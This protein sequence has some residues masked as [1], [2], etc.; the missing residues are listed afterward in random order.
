MKKIAVILLIVALLPLSMV[1]AKSAKRN[2]KKFTKTEL[3]T[4]SDSINYAMGYATGVQNRYDELKDDTLNSKKSAS[5]CMGIE[6]AYKE[7]DAVSNARMNGYAIAQSIKSIA[8]GERGQMIPIDGFKLN[9]DTLSK[10]LINAITKN[11]KDFDFKKYSTFVNENVFTPL[12]NGKS[13]NLTQSMTDSISLLFGYLNGTNVLQQ[14]VK[15][16]TNPDLIKTLTDS[17][18]DYIYSKNKINSYNKGEMVGH[19]L[20]E[21]IGD[22]QNFFDSEK[23]A[24]NKSMFLNGLFDGVMQNP[25]SPLDF[26]QSK[27]YLDSVNQKIQQDKIAENEKLATEAAMKNQQEG[28]AFLLNNGMRPE[29]TTTSSGLQYEIVKQGEGPKPT[30][31]STVKVHYEGKFLDGTVFDSSINR[32]EPIEF[33]PTQVI[34]GWTEGLKLMPVGS[35]YIFYIPYDLAYGPNGAGGVI[36]PYATLIFEVELLEIVD[37]E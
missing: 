13:I 31:S 32:G 3:T 35:K 10:G 37:N 24:V 4:A 15:A 14:M 19:M 18:N 21:Q 12:Q 16:D 2:F 9:I 29:V 30:E 8:D 1:N 23:F 22:L 34:K 7:K 27:N 11:T 28:F 36:P 6:S 25:M 26:E 17:Y 20:W 33:I 5:F